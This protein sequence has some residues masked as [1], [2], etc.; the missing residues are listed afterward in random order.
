MSVDQEKTITDRIFVAGIEGIKKSDL[1]REFSDSDIDGI[2]EHIAGSGIV[3]IEKR[4]QAY[5]CWHREHY[6]EKLLKADP[7]F[8][9]SYEMISSLERSINTTSDSLAIS[10]EKLSESI[11]DFLKENKNVTKEM[12]EDQRIN[13]A[14]DPQIPTNRQ[15][16]IMQLDQFKNIF[17]GV[18]SKHSDSLRWMELAK[19]RAEICDQ[20]AIT[21]DQFYSLVEQLTSQYPDKYELSSGGQE[22]LTLRGLTHGLVRYIQ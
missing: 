8:R 17:D 1:R 5:Y 13:G 6:L 3:C 22:G 2:L 7:R 11:A 14:P 21:N 15:V 4:G 16:V 19:I 18:L 20:F 10:M 9:L 12:R